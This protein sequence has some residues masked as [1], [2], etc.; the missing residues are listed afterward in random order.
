MLWHTKRV[1]CALADFEKKYTI[2]YGGST[3]HKA[4][5]NSFLTLM[6]IVN[7]L[8]QTLQCKERLIFCIS[9][10]NMKKNQHQE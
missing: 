7:F 4:K 10:K 9:H 2:N 3:W 5:I 6:L 1:L 8:V